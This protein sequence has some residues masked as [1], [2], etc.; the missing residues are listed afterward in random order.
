MEYATT[1][2]ATLINFFHSLYTSDMDRALEM[3]GILWEAINNEGARD[4][5]KDFSE[6]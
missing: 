2:E 3:E 6:E 1:I 4:L 5:E